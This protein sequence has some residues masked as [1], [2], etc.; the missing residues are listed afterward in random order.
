[1]R[2]F[3]FQTKIKIFFSLFVALLLVKT[4][5][6]QIFIANTPQINPNFVVKLRQIPTSIIARIKNIGQPAPVAENNNKKNNLVDSQIK[7]LNF[8]PVA[9][10]IKA[11]EVPNSNIKYWQIEA[12]TKLKVI[13][14]QLSNGKQIKIYIPAE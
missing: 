3:I 2:H 14:Y 13:T 12:G 10:G 1:M 11:A 4:L 6:P 9:K 5:S 8:I 7:D